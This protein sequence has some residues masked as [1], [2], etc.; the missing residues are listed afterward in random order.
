MST[1][2]L[3]KRVEGT[4]CKLKFLRRVVAS[5]AVQLSLGLVCAILGPPKAA[6]AD[7][8]T[9]TFG[10]FIPGTTAPSPLTFPD[11]L[12]INSGS[13]KFFNGV[14]FD[15]QWQVVWNADNL[16]M[17]NGAAITNAGRWEAR[18][19]NTLANNG[20]AVPSFT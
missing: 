2:F 8:F 17:Q 10:N 16:F 7:T 20:G 19:N 6:F 9:W 4:M 12:Q 15:N 18:G 11:I 3:G 13:N 5:A 14:A 1:Q